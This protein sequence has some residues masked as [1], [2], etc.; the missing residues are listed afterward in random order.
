[1]TR[2]IKMSWALAGAVAVTACSEDD[3]NGGGSNGNGSAVVDMGGGGPDVG[4]GSDMGGGPLNPA[5]TAA[6]RQ[7]ETEVAAMLPA[8]FTDPVEMVGPVEGDV[9]L[10]ADFAG[11][12]R[13]DLAN[14]VGCE[15]VVAYGNNVEF[16]VQTNEAMVPPGTPASIP[17][18]DC[19]AKA[20]E[21]TN[22][23]MSK[24]IVIL[25]HGNSSSVTSFEEYFNAGIA[26][27]EVTTFSQ[28]SFNV[29]TTVREQLATKLLNDGFEVIAFDAR[30]DLVNQLTD[31]DV[32]AN[33]NRNIDHGWSVPMLQSLVNAVMTNNP[34]RRISLIGHSLGTTMIRDALRRMYVAWT[35]SEAGALN[36][37]P[38]LADVILASGANHGVSTG[39]LCDPMV[40]NMS[41]AVTC[42]MGDRGAFLP[43]Y[44]SEVNNGPNDLYT[45][46]CADGSYAFGSEDQCGNNVVD[47]TTIT[48]EDVPD[49]SFQDEFVSES[50][51]RL[52]LE[53]CVDNELVSLADFDASGYFFDALPG[54]LANHFGSIRSDAG[55]AIILDKLND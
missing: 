33:A 44:F 42:E 29:E 18:Y 38:Q 7:R 30:T 54:F 22:V 3:N 32:M 55:M 45:A 26:G 4:E 28:F 35:D 31:Y 46:P 37:F 8:P 49:G 12:Y 2:L 20:Y 34:G 51:A 14:H 25:V 17:G 41:I 15:P 11:R 21:T 9:A 43:T 39:G 53:P 6:I 16:L 27:T 5:C 50:S 48:M 36:P 1:M 23:D 19:A 13:D 52:D 10:E 40:R 47:Y 24:P